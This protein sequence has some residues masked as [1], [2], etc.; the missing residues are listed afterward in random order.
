MSYSLH[1]IENVKFCE[2]AS[3]STHP[4]AQSVTHWLCL[5]QQ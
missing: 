1:T 2:V 5:N 4:K 3:M